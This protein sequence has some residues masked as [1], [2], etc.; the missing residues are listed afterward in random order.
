MDSSDNIGYSIILIK[1]IFEDSTK[2]KPKTTT[3]NKQNLLVFINKYV[4]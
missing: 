4:C 3:N 2:R 1:A